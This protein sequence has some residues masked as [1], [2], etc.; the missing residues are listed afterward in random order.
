MLQQIRREIVSSL[1]A[2]DPCI[3]SV[4]TSRLESK[5]YCFNL[6]FMLSESDAFTLAPLQAGLIS[7]SDLSGY[8]CSQLRVRT[9]YYPPEVR[10]LKFRYRTKVLMIGISRIVYF[11]EDVICIIIVEAKSIMHFIIFD[12]IVN[13]STQLSSLPTE[14]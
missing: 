13:V 1:L 14:I 12:T 3:R 5:L 2:T 7:S 10:E 6:F 11:N 8:R 9:I 4:R